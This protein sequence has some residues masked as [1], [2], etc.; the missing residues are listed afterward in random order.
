MSRK[1]KQILRF[2]FLIVMPHCMYNKFFLLFLFC[3]L[4][5]SLLQINTRIENMDTSG[6]DI[7]QNA[8]SSFLMGMDSEYRREVSQLLQIIAGARHDSVHGAHQEDIYRSG[9]RYEGDACMHEHSLSHGSATNDGVDNSVCGIWCGHIPHETIVRIYARRMAW[10]ESCLEGL[11]RAE[12]EQQWLEEWDA[13]LDS[14]ISTTIQLLRCHDDQECEM[15]LRPDAFEDTERNSLENDTCT[16]VLTE[17]ASYTYT[18]ALVHHYHHHH[19]ELMTPSHGLDFSDDIDHERDVE[20]RVYEYDQRVAMPQQAHGDA[21]G[22]WLDEKVTPLP[23]LQKMQPAVA[24]VLAHSRSAPSSSPVPVGGTGQSAAR[25]HLSR[26]PSPTPPHSNA[27]YSSDIRRTPS[28][29]SNMSSMQR[30]FG[31]DTNGRA[32]PIG[33]R[34]SVANFL[35]QNSKRDAAAGYGLSGVLAFDVDVPK[36]RVSPSSAAPPADKNVPCVTEE[37]RRNF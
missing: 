22:V 4:F 25:R 26:S 10:I 3:L 27:H 14:M 15:A 16:P 20:M 29:R 11:L 31:I 30:S 35:R 9:S 19:A 12:I 1:N 6:A 17:I 18:T 21:T 7:S 36:Q 2:T 28:L 37:R 24:Q 33:G 34:M 23:L 32:D 13:L 8:S 5:F